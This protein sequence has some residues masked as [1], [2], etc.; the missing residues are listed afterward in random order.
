VL[1]VRVW[2]SSQDVLR[3]RMNYGLGQDV[4]KVRVNYGQDWEMVVRVC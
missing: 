3:V 4:L 2:W 1:R